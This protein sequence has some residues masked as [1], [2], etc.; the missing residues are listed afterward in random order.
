MPSTPSRKFLPLISCSQ[1]LWGFLIDTQEVTM[2][3]FP[4]KYIFNLASVVRNPS[5]PCKP[6]YT[7]TYSGM[8]LNHTCK[9][10]QL[11]LKN[12]CLLDLALKTYEVFWQ[13]RRKLPW[14]IFLKDMYYITHI[15]PYGFNCKNL[16]FPWSLAMDKTK[17]R[18]TVRS[19]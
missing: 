12:F 14:M 15:L 9:C 18:N 3:D 8:G 5:F 2:N 16:Y 4:E 7:G 10:P 19:Y 13:T 6:L 1:N 11:L 17:Q